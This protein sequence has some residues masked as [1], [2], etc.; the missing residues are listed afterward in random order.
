MSQN[1]IL[2]SDN[3]EPSDE[4]LDAEIVALYRT[5]CAVYG[6]H[7]GVPAL[8]PVRWGRSATIRA[9]RIGQAGRFALGRSL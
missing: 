6:P 4:S 8:Q 5:E 3:S 1:R 7:R 2:N 9:R